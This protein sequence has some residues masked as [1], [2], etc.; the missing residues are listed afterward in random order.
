ME[1]I[2]INLLLILFVLMSCSKETELISFS[3]EG[4][5]INDYGIGLNG[6]KVYYSPSEFVTTD[7]LGF[8]KIEN[9]INSV[10][11]EPKNDSYSFTPAFVTVNSETKN[12]EFSGEKS[13]NSIEASVFNWISNQ[14]LPNGLVRSSENNNVISLYDNALA[15][16]VFL[17]QED[18]S[19]AEKIFDF[20][21]ARINSELKN[22]VGGF[23]QFR[24]ENGIP[25]NHRWM[26]DNAWLLIALNNYRERTQSSKYDQLASE[27]ETWLI[28]LQDTDGGLFAGYDS[29]GNLLNFKV[30]EGNIDAFNAIQGYSDVHR[31]LL[32]F[33]EADRWNPTN[34]TIMAWPTNPRYTYALDVFPWS[35]LIF[36]DFPS[37]ILQEAS[38]FNTTKT[39][40]LGRQIIGFCFDEDK[41]VVW[42]EG[43]AQMSL[44][45][46]IAGNIYQN[47][48]YEDELEKAFLTSSTCS[49]CLGMPYATN[50]GTHYGGDAL[51]TGADTNI[52]LSSGAWY[53]F[54]T[55]KFN[56]FRVER[57]KP[58]PE[59][60]MFW[61]N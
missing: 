14:Q 6:I 60:D 46:A 32:E 40:S 59:S 21:N 51:W 42:L 49:N 61:K 29:N 48:F 9:M 7:S 11:I 30:T 52:A 13:I 57:N 55:F 1:H 39:D 3:A 36:K 23:S 35:Y 27:L 2:K 44:A 58:I 12:I 4:Q 41:D 16:L 5:V 26:G 15:A 34:K 38:R 54:S 8:W 56:P 18:I 10:Q 19:K 25:N 22:G 37:N 31:K 33:L 43:T 45:F 53:L 17:L 24:N 47:E 28:N 20:F 50:P